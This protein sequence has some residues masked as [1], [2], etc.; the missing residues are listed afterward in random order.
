MSA[1]D[2]FEKARASHDAGRLLEAKLLL[3]A[4][5]TGL[6]AEV[7]VRPVVTGGTTVDF[8]A[9]ET[10]ERRPDRFR[11]YR[12]SLDLDLTMLTPHGGASAARLRRRIHDFGFRIAGVRGL[13]VEQAR[14]WSHPRLPIGIDLMASGF[15]GDPDRIVRLDV[16]GHEVWLRGPEDT[17]YEHVEWGVHAH[18][19]ASWTRALAVAAA[20]RDRLDI[21]YLRDLAK[22]RG[23]EQALDECLAGKPLA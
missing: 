10:V 16:D 7:D 23:Y 17:L 15:H 19:Q 2:A 4:A 20:Q 18:D 22:S 14:P 9:A 3:A 5:I 1:S 11:G 12:Q 21:D 13:P 8:Y 6:G